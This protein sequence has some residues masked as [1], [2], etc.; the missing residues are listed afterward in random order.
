[1]LEPTTTFNIASIDSPTTIDMDG[2]TVDV[3][4]QYISY[5][6]SQFAETTEERLAREEKNTAITITITVAFLVLM[7]LRIWYRSII[8]KSGRIPKFFGFRKSS[9]VSI[10]INLG[11]NLMLLERDSIAEKRKFMRS[12]FE[13]NYPGAKYNI[14]ISMKNAQVNPLRNESVGKWFQKKLK[15]EGA[16]SNILYFAMGICWAD[17]RMNSREKQRMLEFNEALGL[18]LN[19]FNEIV[20]MYEARFYREQEEEQTKT[21][22]EQKVQRI[23][24]RAI[25]FSILGME[26]T[27]DFEDVK[28]KYR[29][30]AKIH[31]PDMLATKTVLEQEIAEQKFIEI[32]KAYEA[33][34]ELLN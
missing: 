32:K 18:P 14:P 22:E 1:M 24:L 16:R 31:H 5:H 12:Y 17:G 2:K 6:D 21:K 19:Y 33:L 10:L 28:K 15:D 25:Y 4:D 23:S 9:V 27:T 7:S 26:E 11:Y 30:L 20:A 13:R 8:W 29:K 34:E 3:S